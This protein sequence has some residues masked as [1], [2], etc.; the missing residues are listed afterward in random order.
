M[1]Q[2]QTIQII[3]EIK[4]ALMHGDLTIADAINIVIK[5]SR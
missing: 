4:W 5:E 2:C 3:I 1:F